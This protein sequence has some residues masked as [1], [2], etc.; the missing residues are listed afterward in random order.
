MNE[1]ILL[2]CKRHQM[3]VHSDPRFVAAEMGYQ[4]ASTALPLRKDIPLRSCT[5]PSVEYKTLIAK[6]SNTLR[7]QMG[8]PKTNVQTNVLLTF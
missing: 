3:F 4:P 2:S 8:L 6:H 7:S 5:G 1:V